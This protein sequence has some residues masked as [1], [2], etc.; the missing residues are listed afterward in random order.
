M[1]GSVAQLCSTGYASN[2]Y[3]FPLCVQKLMR[4]WFDSDE[5]WTADKW[6]RKVWHVDAEGNRN[7]RIVIHLKASDRY[8]NHELFTNVNGQQCLRMCSAA[9]TISG[10][11]MK[12]RIPSIKVLESHRPNYA[13]YFKRTEFGE[14][15]VCKPAYENYILFKRLCK[16]SVPSIPL[17]ATV[18]QF[19][20]SRVCQ[21]TVGE[22]RHMCEDNLCKGCSFTNYFVVDGNISAAKTRSLA[23]LVSF[24]EKTGVQFIEDSTVLW[25]ELQKVGEDLAGGRKYEHLLHK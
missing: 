10:R 11:K 25:M 21:G 14:C 13:K 20:R 12:P 16:E 9:M 4:D 23:S 19:V 1:S 17:L 22:R 24:T 6:G 18:S 2:L 3:G 8:S 7:S 5:A 15:S